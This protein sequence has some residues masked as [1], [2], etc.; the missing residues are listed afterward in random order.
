MVSSGIDH[1][2]WARRGRLLEVGDWIASVMACVVVVGMGL[3]IAAIL[4]CTTY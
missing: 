1:S 4:L 2:D 3:A